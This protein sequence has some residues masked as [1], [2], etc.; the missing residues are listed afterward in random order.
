MNTRLNSR[1]G[2]TLVELPFGVVSKRKRAAFTLVELLVV[3]A[4]IGILVALLLPAIQAAREAARRNQCLSQIKQL[5]LAMHEFADSR[6]GF[7]LASTAP[8]LQTNELVP[9]GKVDTGVPNAAD[10]GNGTSIQMIA[11]KTPPGNNTGQWGDGYSWIV[12][13]LP[14]MEEKPLYDRISSSSTTGQNK[15]GKLKD[16]AF[17]LKMHVATLGSG[18][19]NTATPSPPGINLYDW[20]TKIPVLQCPSYAGED[21]VSPA[22]FLANAPMTGSVVASC[23]YIVLASTHYFASGDLATGPPVAGMAGAAATNGCGTAAAPKSYCGN[24]GIPFPGATGNG[25]TSQITRLGNSFA[26]FSDGTSKTILLTES[27]EETITSWYSGFASYGV[28]A[29]PNLLGTGE[30]KGSAAP[31]AGSTAPITWTLSGITGGDSSINKGD[32]NAL[33]ITKFY[34]Q[35]SANPHKGSNGTLA[36][37]WGPSSLHPGVIQAGWGDGRGAV[38]SETTD[39]D[40][41]LH[42]ITR[43]GR[44]TDSLP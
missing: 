22:A 16:S 23:N 1:R 31:A 32:R 37:K 9:F 43:N 5:V 20:E 7:P 21:T 41:F 12:Q 30:P 27:R 8:Y 2:F 17:N 39:P 3:I 33:N 11:P 44:E 18:W 28:G 26:S 38:I 19:Q 29:W 25:N 14:Y 24:G 13:I 34:Q 36:R 6:K 40:V 42:L 35:A 10:D 4:I 15:I